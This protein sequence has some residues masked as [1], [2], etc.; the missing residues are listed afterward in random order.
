MSYLFEHLQRGE[1]KGVIPSFSMAANSFLQLLSLLS[2]FIYASVRIFHRFSNVTKLPRLNERR[3]WEL[4]RKPATRRYTNDSWNMMRQAIDRF[5]D[6]P[7]RVSSLD[8]GETVVLP[9]RFVPQ[10]STDPRLSFGDM[11]SAVVG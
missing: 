3:P 1:L 5:V 11:V 2:L 10:V 6:S 9:Q 4:S 7:F 8:R